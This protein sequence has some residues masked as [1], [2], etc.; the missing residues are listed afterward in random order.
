MSV[1]FVQ[2]METVVVGMQLTYP[3]LPLQIPQ[4]ID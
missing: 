1:G 4:S 2:K 3:L